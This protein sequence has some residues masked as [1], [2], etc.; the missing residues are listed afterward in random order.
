MMTNISPETA[1][2]TGWSTRQVYGMAAGCLFL[3][4]ITG[5]LYRGSESPRATVASSVP[6]ADAP[7]PHSMPTMAQMRAMGDKQAEPLLEKL[8]KDPNNPELLAQVGDIYKATHQF[9]EAENYYQKSLKADP[10][11]AD[12]GG[13]LAACLYYTGDVDGAIAQLQQSLKSSPKDANSL[14]NLGVMRWQGKKDGPGA[15]AAWQKLLK[16]NPNLE[17]SKKSQVEQMIAEV[18]K[19]P[20]N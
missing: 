2:N 6:S 10:R 3:G 7:A 5:Y 4:L 9:K 19:A 11:N 8:K 17:E 15:V 16:S 20:K 14:F 13:D 1:A 18:G 12:V